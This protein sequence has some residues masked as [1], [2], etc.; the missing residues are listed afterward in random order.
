MLAIACRD[1]SARDL[2]EREWE[3]EH[4]LPAGTN[5]RTMIKQ[6]QKH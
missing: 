4:H 6:V 5:N 3:K 1:I 2:L